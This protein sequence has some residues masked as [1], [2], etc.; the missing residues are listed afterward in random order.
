ME[1]ELGNPIGDGWPAAI[2]LKHDST[3]TDDSRH[4]RRHIGLFSAQIAGFMS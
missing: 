2:R 3:A 4:P 1:A